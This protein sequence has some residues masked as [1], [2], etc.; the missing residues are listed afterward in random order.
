MT[1]GARAMLDVAA[2]VVLAAC[3]GSDGGT[4]VGGSPITGHREAGMVGTVTAT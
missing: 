4:D 2:V 1:S 3:G